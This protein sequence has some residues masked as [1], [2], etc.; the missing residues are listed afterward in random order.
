MLYKLLGKAVWNGSKWYLGR[1]G[2]P[3]PGPKTLAAGGALALTIGA[4]AVLAKRSMR[5]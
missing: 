1:R 5:H 3:R 2:R 4:A